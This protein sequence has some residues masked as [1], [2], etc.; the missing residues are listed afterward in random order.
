M[1]Y[2]DTIQGKICSILL[3]FPNTLSARDQTQRPH[4]HLRPPIALRRPRLS[5]LLPLPPSLDLIQRKHICIVVHPL[6]QIQTIPHTRTD[7][8]TAP[9]DKVGPVCLVSLELRG[10]HDGSNLCGSDDLCVPGQ[11]QEIVICCRDWTMVVL[12]VGISGHDVD[13]GITGIPVLRHAV[14]DPDQVLQFVHAGEAVK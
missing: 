6:Q 4:C 13:V 8:V 10:L 9:D 5:P 1:V 11:G 7:V 12:R 2:F 14:P 3:K